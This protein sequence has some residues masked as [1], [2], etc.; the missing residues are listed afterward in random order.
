MGSNIEQILVDSTSFQASPDY[1]GRETLVLKAERCSAMLTN[2]FKA[3][4]WARDLFIQA[5]FNEYSQPTLEYSV[6]SLELSEDDKQKLKE[7]PHHV[8]KPRMPYSMTVPKFNLPLDWRIRSGG[9]LLMP[10]PPFLILSFSSRLQV[11]GPKKALLIV[12]CPDK[13]RFWLFSLR[14]GFSLDKPTCSIP[15]L[16]GRHYQL[17]VDEQTRLVALVIT[18]A[19][20]Y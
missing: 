19:V 11:L 18:E 20:C 3:G 12:D 7:N 6:W 14:N 4:T 16:Q 15:N 13:I 5:W 17:A 10:I 2:F 1:R 8:P 9:Y